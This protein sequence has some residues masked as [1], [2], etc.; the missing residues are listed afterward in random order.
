MFVNDYWPCP[1]VAYRW[2]LKSFHVL[3]FNFFFFFFTAPI[4]FLKY[5]LYSFGVVFSFVKNA[6]Q[7]LFYPS[8]CRPLLYGPNK[9]SPSFMLRLTR[10][11]LN[12]AFVWVALSLHTCWGRGVVVF[13]L[14]ILTEIFHYLSWNGLLLQLQRHFILGV[15]L[16]PPTRSNLFAIHTCWGPESSCQKYLKFL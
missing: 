1:N 2:F 6:W 10:S 13:S 8:S 9:I 11:H 16:Y 15:F 3:C 4:K 12:R 5:F 14:E 7:C